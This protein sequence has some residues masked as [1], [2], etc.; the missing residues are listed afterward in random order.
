MND[1]LMAYTPLNVQHLQR[2][3][4]G[5]TL[6][7]E[8]NYVPVSQFEF[9]IIGPFADLI[10]VFL[11]FTPSSPNPTFGFTFQ[12]YRLLKRAFVNT[13]KPKYPASKIFSNPRST[14]NKLRG[15][16]VTSIHGNPVFTSADYLQQL[17]LLHKQ[18]VLELS[19]AFTPGVKLSLKEVRRATNECGLFSH[20]T[21]LDEVAALYQI[22]STS[23]TT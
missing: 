20:N 13:I 3:N 18:G 6:P 10:P 8:K 15:D 14:N 9:S 4:N 11:K 2:V 23:T 7:E 17:C 19:L 22:R 16:F 21:R 12:Y 5:Q 1:L